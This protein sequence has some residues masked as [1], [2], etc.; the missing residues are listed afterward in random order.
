MTAWGAASLVQMGLHHPVLRNRK[1]RWPLQIGR[2][3]SINL[4]AR[5]STA[6]RRRIRIS[7]VTFTFVPGVRCNSKITAFK[8]ASNPRRRRV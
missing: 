8:I 4:Q 7:R 3:L 1:S 6:F 5:T 2:N